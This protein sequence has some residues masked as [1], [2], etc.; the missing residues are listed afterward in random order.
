MLEIRLFEKAAERDLRET[1]LVT[2][3]AVVDDLELRKGPWVPEEIEEGLRGFAR[4]VPSIRAISLVTLRDG[5]P[6][7]L[8][9]TASSESNTAIALARE[10]IVHGEQGWR[11][12]GPLTRLALRTS[13]GAG[14]DAAVVV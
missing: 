2:A 8:A 1:G 4:G 6:A 14:G 5:I 7:V 9:S 10:T 12:D 11:D 3:E 13:P